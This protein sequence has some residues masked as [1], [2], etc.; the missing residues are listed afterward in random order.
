MHLV[1]GLSLYRHN[2]KSVR[3]RKNYSTSNVKHNHKLF[4]GDLLSFIQVAA[5]LCFY[6]FYFLL[7]FEDHLHH[8]LCFCSGIRTTDSSCCAKLCVLYQPEWYAYDP[9]DTVK[10]QMHI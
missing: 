7:P 10:L 2:G 4:Y 9:E 6:H 1:C 3:I 5:T 8:L